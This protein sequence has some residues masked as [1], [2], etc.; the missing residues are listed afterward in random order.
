MAPDAFFERLDEPDGNQV[1]YWKQCCSMYDYYVM[2]SKDNP[3]YK[4][5]RAQAKPHQRPNP[6]D[7]LPNKNVAHNP[8]AP[9][10]NAPSDKWGKGLMSTPQSSARANAWRD[11]RKGLMGDTLASP[12]ITSAPLSDKFK[13]ESQVISSLSEEQQHA[14]ERTHRHR[15]N[16]TRSNIPV[17][18]SDDSSQSSQDDD[19][20]IFDDKL[21]PPKNKIMRL[22]KEI[23][24]IKG[25]VVY[26]TG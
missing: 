14:A 8:Y 12:V 15:T 20:L 6:R 2:L 7:Y 4:D 3:Q 10:D 5:K 26:P 25:G 21:L 19:D 18:S 24:R 16:T 1:I 9:G 22:R 17:P 23:T 11:Q 13:F